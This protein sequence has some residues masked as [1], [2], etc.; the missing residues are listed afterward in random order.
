MI[1]ITADGT[2]PS[3]YFDALGSELDRAVQTAVGK[4]GSWLQ[5]QV[6][7]NAKTGVHAPGRPHI[8]GTGPGP[9]V[10]SGDYRNSIALAVRVSGGT[11]LATVSTNLVQA[12]RLE[13]GFIGVDSLGRAY[14]QPPYPHWRPAVMLAPAVFSQELSR[15]LAV[16]GRRA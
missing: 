3:R 8:P 7:A 5:T 11:H 4:T 16:T 1:S 14:R 13:F 6:R 10:A 2:D 12:R 15:A 9:N